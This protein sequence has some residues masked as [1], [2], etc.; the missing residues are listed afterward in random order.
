MKVVFIISFEVSFL[1]F[2]SFFPKVDI[3]QLGGEMTAYTSCYT[4]LNT[5]KPLA[6]YFSDRFRCSP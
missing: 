2:L 3:W 4:C 5:A 6:A 1:S